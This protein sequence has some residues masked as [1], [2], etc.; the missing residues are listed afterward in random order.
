MAIA[1]S[2]AAGEIAPS[3]RRSGYDFMSRETRAMQDDDSANPGMLW[4]LDGETLWRKKEGAAGKACSDCH[5]QA[6]AGMKGVA[7][8]YPAFDAKEKRPINL[9][10]RI[11]KCRVERQQ[12]AAL[13]F[14]SKDLLSL[15]A[16]VA[17][18]SRGMPIAISGDDRTKRFIEAGRETFNRR[19]GQ[20]NLSCRQCHDDN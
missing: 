4:V 7:A 5:G 10:Q 14:E 8:R 1:V 16:F 6:E 15:T 17:Q 13:G 2:V 9:E 3:G 20:I 11:D 12:A 19:Q 18:Q